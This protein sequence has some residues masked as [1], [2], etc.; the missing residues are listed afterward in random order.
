MKFTNVVLG[1]FVSTVVG[2]VL[3]W[4]IIDKYLW[5]YIS[6]EHNIEKKS[7]ATFSVPLGICER[8]LYTTAFL[9][10][11]HQWVGVWLAIKVA[12]QWHR[13]SH[14]QRGIDNIF[15][16]GNSISILVSVA[17]ASIAV[18]HILSFSN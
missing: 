16:I 9:I 17:G 12:V 6:K 8:L 15:L 10:G 2:G 18:G 7:S 3:L 11:A 13:W 14:A 5:G 4:I 1:Y